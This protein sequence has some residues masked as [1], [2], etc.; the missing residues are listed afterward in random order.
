MKFI[1]LLDPERL[2]LLAVSLLLSVA[3][4]LAGAD[5][6]TLAALTA[7]VTNENSTLS[8]VSSFSLTG[9]TPGAALFNITDAL[10]GQSV[11]KD[12]TVTTVGTGNL[13]LAIAAGSAPGVVAPL[14]NAA[15]DDRALMVRVEQCGSTFAQAGC[16]GVTGLNGGSAVGVA[17]GANVASPN[18]VTFNAAAAAAPITL[19]SAQPSGDY[20]FKVFLRIPVNT[21]SGGANSD[22][23]FAA[24]S[25]KVTMT[26]QLTSVDGSL[27]STP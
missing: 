15:P 11:E 18:S 24:K 19:L 16:S 7:G 2:L 22:T 5:K 4:A 20:Y 14:S 3:F 17:S 10:P 27:R 25:V 12:V 8:T 6:G 26:W 1:Y 9:T 23:T 13:T 21:T